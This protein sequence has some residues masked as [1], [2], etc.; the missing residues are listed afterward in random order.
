MAKYMDGKDYLVVQGGTR[1]VI[2]VS[3]FLMQDEA[4]S[5]YQRQDYVVA[6]VDDQSAA[7]SLDWDNYHLAV[8]DSYLYIKNKSGDLKRIELMDLA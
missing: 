1:N 5:D 7:E 3:D 4:K 6:Q 2:P 8:D